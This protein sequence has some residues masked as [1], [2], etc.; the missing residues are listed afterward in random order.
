MGASDAEQSGSE[1]D[2]AGGTPEIKLTLLDDRPTTRDK[3]DLDSYAG[4]LE[5]L[6]VGDLA[7]SPFTIAINAPWGAG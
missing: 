7:S 1:T 2:S 3:L 6:I 5:S 4:A